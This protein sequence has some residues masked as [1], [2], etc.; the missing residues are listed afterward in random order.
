MKKLFIITFLSCIQLITAQTLKGVVV[1]E[2]NEY[3]EYVDFGI[4]GKEKSFTSD[5]K[6]LFS[7]DVSSYKPTDSL[8]FTHF[9]FHRKSIAIKDFTKTITLKENAFELTPIVIDVN[10]SKLK[11]IKSKGMKVPGATA[12]FSSIGEASDF[13]GMGDFVTLKHDYVAKE[14][15][16]QYL[17]ND[18][19]QVVFR[20]NFYKVEKN[21]A[22]T[23]LNEKPIYINFE[24]TKRKKDLVEQFSVNL[25]KGKI[26]IEFDIVEVA[27][28]E[29]AEIH[30][31]I[32][33]SGGWIRYDRRFEKIPMGM[34]L[35]FE[36]KGYKAE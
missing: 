29:S 15:H 1:N 33:L 24:P 14:L 2:H 17:F 23:P 13:F 26:W 25:P 16:T 18:L 9:N 30:F 8:Y 3:I 4:V 35:S 11:T 12:I 5:S 20:L 36:I 27:G 22:L 19:K 32:S 28:N 31:P 21:N 34:G 7:I 10:K 6:G